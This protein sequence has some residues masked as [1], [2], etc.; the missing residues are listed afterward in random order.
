MDKQ[1]RCE[2]SDLRVNQTKVEV[3]LSQSVCVC[4]CWCWV[5]AHTAPPPTPIYHLLY[6][7]FTLLFP[8]KDSTY[9]IIPCTCDV[10]KHEYMCVEYQSDNSLVGER[11]AS[12]QPCLKPGST[13]MMVQPLTGHANSRCRRFLTNMT[14]DSF[15]AATVSLVLNR[16]P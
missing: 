6:S 11:T 1:R 9:I 8:S 4:V 16:Q 15:S 14:M 3:K 2:E 7:H 5:I 12:L 13:P 10:F